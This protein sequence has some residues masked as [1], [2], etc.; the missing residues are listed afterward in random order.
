MSINS[1]ISPLLFFFLHCSLVIFT[2][3]GAQQHLDRSVY[4][5][6]ANCA[7]M[8]FFVRP[9][10]FVSTTSILLEYWLGRL[11]IPR[12]DYWSMPGYPWCVVIFIYHIFYNRFAWAVTATYTRNIL[13]IFMPRYRRFSFTGIQSWYYLCHGHHDRGH[14]D[15]SDLLYRLFRDCYRTF[16]IP[17]GIHYLVELGIDPWNRWRDGV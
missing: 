5:L 4:F 6:Y 9:Y 12:L 15:R 16:R 13:F 10:I 1:T 17:K 7:C 3:T 2:T 11:H 8:F 14:M